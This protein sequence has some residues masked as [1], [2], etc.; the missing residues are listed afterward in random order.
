MM[1]LSGLL[2]LVVWF[3]N[4][5]VLAE[6]TD[7]SSAAEHP[8]DWYLSLGLGANYGARAELDGLGVKVEYDLGLPRVKGGAGWRLGKH[9]WLDASVSQ[10]KTKAE[11]FFPT[12]G[13][14]STDV[15]ANDR[16]S[17][18]S[19]MLSALR[20]FQV[21]PWLKPYLGIGVGPTWLTY[22]NSIKGID[23]AEDTVIIQDDSTAVAYQGVVGVRFPLTRQ[24]DLGLEYEYWRTPNVDLET[25][26]GEDV[27]LDQAVHSGWVSLLWYPG[28]DRDT[29]FGRARKTGPASRGFYLAGSTGVNWLA[30]RETEAVTF[31]AAA[32]G[33]LI[34][35]A[36]GHNLGRRWRL[37]LE[38]AYRRNTPQ[39]LDFGYLIGESKVSGTLSASSLGANLHLDPWP[40]AAVQ[41]TIGLGVGWSHLDYDVDFADGEPFSSSSVDSAHFQM[42]AGFNVEISRSLSFRTA[43]RFW[44][45]AEEDLPLSDGSVLETNRLANSVEFGLI[46]RLAD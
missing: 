13:G 35:T 10:R 14:P 6:E 36:V 42:M 8:G 24:L 37:E 9:W 46:Y 26:D 23:G 40:E 45:T 3:F 43:W 41:P 7:A 5:S 31:D 1:R 29:A 22:Q 34:S 44:L 25:L 19:L 28:T 20:E 27:Q 2:G 11:F 15:G 38:Y 21:G 32:P 30:D 17:S 33:V 18:V 16:Y 12:A 39:V 4:P